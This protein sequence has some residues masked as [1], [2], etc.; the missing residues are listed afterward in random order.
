MDPSGKQYVDDHCSTKII[1]QCQ[2]LACPS[3]LPVPSN[4]LFICLYIVG[5]D[6][7]AGIGLPAFASLCATF[8]SHSCQ[9][10]PQFW[11]CMRAEVISWSKFPRITSQLTVSGQSCLPVEIPYCKQVKAWHKHMFLSS[12]AANLHSTVT[13]NKMQ[14]DSV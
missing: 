2:L 1:L 3:V 7:I 12:F 14:Y 13:S 4:K 10:G 8:F 11:A 6:S 5:K 9:T